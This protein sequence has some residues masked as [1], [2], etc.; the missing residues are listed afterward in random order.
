MSRAASG[1]VVDP[2]NSALLLVDLQERLLPAIHGG[3][4]VVA[5]ASW[6]CRVADRVG[7][8]IHATEQNPE[9]LGPTAPSVAR[10]LRPERTHAKMH[11]G[12]TREAGVLEAF[13][14]SQVVVGGTE[15]HV[16]VLQTVLG[17]LAAGRRV[18]VVDEAVGSRTPRDRDRALERVRGAGAVVVTREMVAFEW[19]QRAGTATFRDLLP[20]IRD[21]VP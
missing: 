17:L 5:A 20:L 14:F 18:F 6:L 3:T 15:A 7:V 4:Q 8:P 16:C 1:A 13:P 12:W 21:P 11:F 10:W 9:R 2:H 19:L